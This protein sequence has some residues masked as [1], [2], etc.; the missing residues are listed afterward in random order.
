MAAL[1]PE[2]TRATG[3][4]QPPQ[5]PHYS[6]SQMG[7]SRPFSLFLSS[8][9]NCADEKS[10]KEIFS[11][12]GSEPRISGVESDNNR[13]TLHQQFFSVDS[14]QWDAWLGDLFSE[15]HETTK[16]RNPDGRALVNRNFVLETDFQEIEPK[17]KRLR[18]F[19]RSRDQLR[20]PSRRR[21]IRQIPAAGPLLGHIQL[22]I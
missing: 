5:T 19:V 6:Y 18:F 15:S 2:L 12:T 13:F 10:H 8:L 20:P 7:I 17:F 21:S 14:N 9:Y 3:W 22:P 16:R 4:P 1:K 11:T